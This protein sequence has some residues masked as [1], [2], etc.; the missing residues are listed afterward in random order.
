MQS[1]VCVLWPT[2]GSTVQQ[3]DLLD[4]FGLTRLDHIV[5]VV[6]KIKYFE[7]ELLSFF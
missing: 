2:S 3:G 5:V 4:Y 6:L 7:S 1:E